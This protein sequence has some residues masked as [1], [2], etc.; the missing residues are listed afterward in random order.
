MRIFSGAPIFTSPRAHFGVLNQILILKLI[1][2]AI[3]LLVNFLCKLKEIRCIC[4]SICKWLKQFF[5]TNTFNKIKLCIDWGV[6]DQSWSRFEKTQT[7]TDMPVRIA[8]SMEEHRKI[9]RNGSLVC[10]YGAI[11]FQLI[12]QIW[13]T[14]QSLP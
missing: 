11:I 1:H 13:N 9:G 8:L 10:F 14:L 3:I 12:F 6:L 4:C 5:L 7:S 2:S